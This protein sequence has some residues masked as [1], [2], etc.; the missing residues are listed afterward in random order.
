VP[1]VTLTPHHT[2]PTVLKK[3]AISDQGPIAASW[4]EFAS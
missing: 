1:H 4:L 2:K 3:K